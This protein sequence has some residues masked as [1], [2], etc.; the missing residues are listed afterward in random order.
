MCIA[1]NLDAMSAYYM[2][3]VY[4]RVHIGYTELCPPFK[5]AD[6]DIF[7]LMVEFLSEK[8]INVI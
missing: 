1:H 5:F 7:V 6:L 3:R 8:L 4:F 2:L